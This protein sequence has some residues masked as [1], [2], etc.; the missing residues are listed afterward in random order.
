M[1][2]EFFLGHWPWT[3]PT[4]PTFPKKKKKASLLYVGGLGHHSLCILLSFYLFGPWV[5]LDC[6]PDSRCTQDDIS[7]MAFAAPLLSKLL[8]RPKSHDCCRIAVGFPHPWACEVPPSPLYSPVAWPS[9]GYVSIWGPEG[10]I[11]IHPQN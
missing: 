5:Y 8:L 11:R 10:V 4:S 6:W 3:S 9:S 1:S 2:Q 7:G